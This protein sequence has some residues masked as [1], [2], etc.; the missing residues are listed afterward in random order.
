MVEDAGFGGWA[1]LSAHRRAEDDALVQRYAAGEGRGQDMR[2]VRGFV[3]H[4]RR[5]IG[6]KGVICRVR[7]TE[8]TRGH[9]VCVWFYFPQDGRPAAT[10]QT[11]MVTEAHTSSGRPPAGRPATGLTALARAA[12]VPPASAPGPRTAP[13]TTATSSA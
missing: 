5:D 7:L 11:A 13:G 1:D 3:Q 10:S 4:V 8:H 9:E 6:P 2:P 12:T